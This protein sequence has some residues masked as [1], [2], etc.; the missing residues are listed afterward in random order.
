MVSGQNGTTLNTVKR[1]TSFKSDKNQI[2]LLK[3]LKSEGRQ[4]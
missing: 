3:G 1:A 2:G 4:E